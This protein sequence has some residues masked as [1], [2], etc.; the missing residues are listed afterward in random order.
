MY[1]LYSAML[2][3][4][5]AAYSP[6]FAVRRLGRGGYQAGFRQRLGQIEPGLPA[7]PRCW[8]HAVSVGEVAAAAPLVRGIRR[9]WPEMSVV[10]TTVT[11]TGAR[12]VADQLLVLRPEHGAEVRHRGSATARLVRFS[13]RMYA[14]LDVR[15]AVDS[16]THAS[17][18]T[19]VALTWPGASVTLVTP[20]AM[21]RRIINAGNRWARIFAAARRSTWRCRW[22]PVQ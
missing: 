1:A 22:L 4:A 12:V 9:R 14:L 21:A 3:L 13:M 2:T 19:T 10:L 5:L 11:P 16:R 7:A 17:W 8:V 15:A 6:V 20:I 18:I